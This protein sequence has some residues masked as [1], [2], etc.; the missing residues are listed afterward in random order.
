MVALM[1]TVP[2]VVRLLC[3]LGVACLLMQ[4]LLVSLS[5]AVTLSTSLLRINLTKG[6]QW[7]RKENS[8]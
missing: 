2:W 1:P 5:T 8:A 4:T 3:L 6:E 7:L